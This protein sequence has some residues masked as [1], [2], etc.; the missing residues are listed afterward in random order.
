MR[1][2]SVERALTNA[3]DPDGNTRSCV[4]EH[5]D[6][7]MADEHGARARAG[8]S[9]TLVQPPAALD[10]HHGPGGLQLREGHA[11]PLLRG[12]HDNQAP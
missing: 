6:D 5:S 8:Q 12:I 7:P 3:F 1:C 2:V 10:E 11:A 4:E 9:E